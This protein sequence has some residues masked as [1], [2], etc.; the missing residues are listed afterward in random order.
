MPPISSQCLDALPVPIIAILKNR[1]LCYDLQAEAF[2][3]CAEPGQ[4]CLHE[5][6]IY[7]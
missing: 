3:G 4:L 6:V 7:L 1:E 5:A 2:C